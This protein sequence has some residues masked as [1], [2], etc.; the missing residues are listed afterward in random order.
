MGELLREREGE[1]SNNPL[2]MTNYNVHGLFL[3]IGG[4]SVKVLP[5][6][7]LDPGAFLEELVRLWPP[8]IQGR[9]RFYRSSFSDE[10][11]RVVLNIR[12]TL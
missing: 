8:A 2:T 7:R 1:L 4:G 11:A 10:V 9:V 6:S 12:K 3:L 5:K